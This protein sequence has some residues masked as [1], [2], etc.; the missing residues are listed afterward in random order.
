M[1]GFSATAQY[2]LE[3]GPKKLPKSGR[4]GSPSFADYCYT[5]PH[6]QRERW[7]LGLLL[8][9]NKVCMALSLSEIEVTSLLDEV[10]VDLRCGHINVRSVNRF[11]DRKQLLLGHPHLVCL[12]FQF[13]LNA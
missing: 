11:T 3:P 12:S 13:H 9:E 7:L 8:R 2:S 5:Q 4:S 6:W 1:V 10:P